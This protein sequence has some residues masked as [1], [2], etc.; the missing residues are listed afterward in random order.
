[1]LKKKGGSGGGGGLVGGEMAQTMYT[2]MNKWIYKKNELLAREG[3]ML[4]NTSVV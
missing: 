3:K 1:M 4:K 2:H